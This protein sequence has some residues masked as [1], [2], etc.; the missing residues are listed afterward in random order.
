MNIN[1]DW[2]FYINGKEITP[3][4]FLVHDLYSMDFHFVIHSPDDKSTLEWGRVPKIIIKKKE[5]EK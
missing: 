1:E 4:E 3:R 2:K 5:D